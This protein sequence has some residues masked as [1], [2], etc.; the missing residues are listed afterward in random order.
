MTK[1]R[2][3][4]G[5]YRLARLIRVGSSCSV[6]EAIKSGESERYA[7]KVLRSDQIGN[8]SEEGYLKHEFNVSRSF[9]HPRVIKIYELRNDAQVPYLVLELFSEHNMKQALR[10]GHERLAFYAKTIIEQ[11]AEALYH[12][13]S[14]GWI[15]CD[16]KP[17]NILV[18]NSGEVKL[19]DFT[20]ARKIK[21][22]LGKLFSFGGGTVQGT[23]SYMSP[24]QIRNKVLDQ[25]SDVYSFACVMFELLSGRPP[26]TA[27]TPN[28]L[29]EK[30][31]KAAIP[32]LQVYNSNVSDEVTQLIRTAMSKSPDARPDSMWE[33]LREFRQYRL[34]K[35][36]PKKVA[37]ELPEAGSEDEDDDD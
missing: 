7:L 11:A 24:E 34:F 8:K 36:A 18:S 16:I 6:W 29:L 31:I 13:N 35:K 25:R 30:H 32:S 2:D 3:F 17:D 10:Q 9:K 15:H 26:Y 1:V 23:R 20:I 19:I 37:L 14:K 33:L 12:V 22:G 4:L 21:T 5:P 28:E 27:S